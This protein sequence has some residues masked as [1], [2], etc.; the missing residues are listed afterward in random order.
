[1][2]RVK[3]CDN[4]YAFL[5]MMFLTEMNYCFHGIYR[6]VVINMVNSMLS[7]KQRSAKKVT[8]PLAWTDS[9]CSHPLYKESDLIEEDALGMSITNVRSAPYSF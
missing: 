7:M 4:Q 5:L 6:M 1:M 9:C 2:E 3:V 8:F